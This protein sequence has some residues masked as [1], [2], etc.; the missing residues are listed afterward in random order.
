MQH[1]SNTFNPIP[2]VYEDFDR[3]YS[4]EMLD[5]IAVTSYFK[6]IG[7]SIHPTV[8]FNSVPSGTVERECFDRLIQEMLIR[9]P[10]DNIDGV[11]LYLHGAM[12]VEG[13]GSGEAAVIS[14]VR[15]KVGPHIPIAV[16]LDFHANNTQSIAHDANIICGYR[17]APHTDMEE[18]QLRAARLLV[19][20][21]KDKRLPKIAMIRVPIII[22]GDKVITKTEPMKS[23]ID[24][25]AMIEK[26][27]GIISASVFNGNPWVDSENNSAS[28]LVVA[29]SEEYYYEALDCAGKLAGM[30]WNARD[31]YRFQ[32]DVLNTR[33]AI[34]TAVNEESKP[35]FISDSGDNTTA[36]A[37]GNNAHLLKHM[38]EIGVTNALL[39]GITDPMV[40]K[41]CRDLNKGDSIPIKIGGNLDRQA[42]WVYLNAKFICRSVLLGWDGDCAGEA[43]VLS[44]PGIDIIVTERPCAII[45]PEI[46]ESAG[47]CFE[48]Y[49]IIAVKLGYLYPKLA[50]R[51]ARAILAL[52]PGNSR[53]DI[54]NLTFTKIRRPLWP[55]DPN[56]KWEADINNE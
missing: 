27:K 22:T 40:I 4:D 53:E 29:Q 44:I 37:L 30:L 6:N 43:V 2:A 48:Q 56:Y 24:N 31:K 8:Y 54:E 35:V 3:F 16:A 9:F 21:I 15:E 17:T 42:D 1:E 51:A 46:I 25:V 14:A 36:G 20:C 18:T 34:V 39:A 32:A 45:S 7:L 33:E 10:Q 41:E 26:K 47:V 28:A 38:I 52:T 11:W 5:K 55:I 19:G 50:A 23:I 13:L 12:E 49:K